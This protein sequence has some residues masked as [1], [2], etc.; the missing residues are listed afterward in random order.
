MEIYITH[1]SPPCILVPFIITDGDRK[2]GG[3]SGF[4]GNHASEGIV[5]EGSKG[6]IRSR[7]ARN[8]NSDC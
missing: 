4:K 3:R 7:W 2:Q 5:E 6:N 8:N 1:L